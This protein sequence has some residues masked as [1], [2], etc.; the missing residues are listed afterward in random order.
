MGTLKQLITDL[1]RAVL[2][3]FF[4]FLYAL[5]FLFPRSRNIWLFDEWD[6]K[7]FAD[8]ARYLYLYVQKEQPSVRGIWLSRSKELVAEMKQEGLP[9]YYAYSLPGL[10]YTLRAKVV[11]FES[12]PSMFYWFLGGI[13]KINLWHG[14]PIKKIVYDS[15][16]T[17]VH[18]WVY[19]ATGLRR[20]YHIFFQPHKIAVGDY[21][22]AQSP[23]W[24]EF[25]A[26]A[27][28][29]PVSNVIVENQPRN[30]MFL[31]DEVLT[32]ES[33]RPLIEKI[34]EL[35][36]TRKVVSYL[37]TFRDGSANPLAKSG[38]DYDELNEVLARHN[39]HLF[40]K[41]HHEKRPEGMKE[42]Y[43]NIDFV[44]ADYSAMLLLRESDALL[45][46][47]SSVYME[48]LVTDRPV[49]FYCFDLDEYVGKMR[50]MYFDY[51]DITPGV[52]AKTPAEFYRA[53]EDFAVGTDAYRE[54][55]AEIRRMVLLPEPEKSS[56]KV[57]NR[58][59]EILGR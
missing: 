5:S 27:F 20:L 18:N 38:I 53:L 19:T 6:G 16:Q 46:D 58:I 23:A 41:L 47:Y 29:V 1:P 17:K 8:N 34:I 4:W 14:L 49:L 32:L 24:R 12:T 11:I 30:E 9:A 37:P 7:R 28:R 48:F 21:V 56:E 50:E 35:R 39:L 52:K 13:V 3:V 36:R 26:S 44:A 2:Y 42:S 45:T 15:A 51:E 10:W 59:S 40:I 31:M 43:S 25:F 57:F 54:A 22:L 33:E 55:R